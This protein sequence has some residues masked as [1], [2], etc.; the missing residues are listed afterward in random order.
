M[1]TLVK[2]MALASALTGTLVA[3]PAQ[4]NDMAEGL[5]VVV[6]SDNHQTQLMAMV[7]SMQTLDKHAK[8]VNM[9]LCGPAGDLALKETKTPKLKPRDVSPTMLLNKIMKL[10]ATVEVCPIYLPNVGKSESDLIDGITVAKPP[11]VAAN[12]LNKNFQNLSY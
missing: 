3:A 10:G 8:K 9:V 11:K 1:K 12:L 7:L 4:A 6:T 2:K 5:N